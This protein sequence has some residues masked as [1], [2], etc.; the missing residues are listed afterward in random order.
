[1]SSLV[2]LEAP[3]HLCIYT[4]KYRFQT[5]TYIKK[6]ANVIHTQNSHSVHIDLSRVVFASAAASVLLFAVLNR[7]QLLI[8]EELFI[9]VSLPRKISNPEGYR[10]IVSTGLG[11][12]LLANTSEKLEALVNEKRYFQSSTNPEQ[13]LVKTVN[14]LTEKALFSEEQF[15]LLAM[16]INEAMLNV[17]NHAYDGS[18]FE[19]MTELMG[20]R[21]WWQCAWFDKARDRVVFIICDLGIGVA[22]S[23]ANKQFI[24]DEDLFEELKCVQT[25][26][27]SGNSRFHTP[28]R[29]NGSEDIKRPIGSG[30][31]KNEQ[32]LVFS[33]KALYRFESGNIDGSAPVCDYLPTRI[34]GTIVQ[35]SLVPKRD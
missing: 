31:T 27:T 8:G 6:I 19:E 20:G 26:L 25:A 29:G 14:M 3:S 12:A 33:G 28:G 5:L 22:S 16:G 35:W 30:C 21:R 4:S 13:S 24:S 15:I 9:R 23:F 32:L 7:A 2:I 18:S 34:Q 11:K 1:M 17:F 10:W